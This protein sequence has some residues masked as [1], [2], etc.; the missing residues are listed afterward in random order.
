MI[1]KK[2]HMCLIL[3]EDKSNFFFQLCIYE[4]LPLQILQKFMNYD[5]GSLILIL[6]VLFSRSRPSTLAKA[7]LILVLRSLGDVDSA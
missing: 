6:S 4:V 1:Y 5:S 3:S 7:S 2:V